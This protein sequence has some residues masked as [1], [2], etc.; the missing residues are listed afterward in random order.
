MVWDENGT[1]GGV[2]WTQNPILFRSALVPNLRY[3]KTVTLA[4]YR[5]IFFAHLEIEVELLVSCEQNLMVLISLLFSL[6]Q[7]SC[8]RQKFAIII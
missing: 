7:A 6:V 1:L 5:A 8:R 3:L 4:A 2:L